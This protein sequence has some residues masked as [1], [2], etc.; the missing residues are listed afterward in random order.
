MA[1]QVYY[2]GQK[3]KSGD[4]M[5][6]RKCTDECS[7]SKGKRTKKDSL[8][9]SARG[10]NVGPFLKGQSESGQAR[11]LFVMITMTLP[12]LRRFYC[13]NR[14]SEFGKNSVHN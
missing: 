13:I 4:N 8:S 1:L 6:R 5:R 10:V 11:L 14:I 9:M 2:E 3:L 12:C 7:L